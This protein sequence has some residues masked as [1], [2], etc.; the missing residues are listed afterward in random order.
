MYYNIDMNYC[1]L[2]IYSGYTFLSSTLKVDDIFKICDKSSIKYFGI[3]DLLNMHAY[4]DITNLQNKYKSQPIYGSTI[5]YLV[6]D[7]YPFLISLY[8]I[9]EEGYLNLVKI[10]S[11]YPEGITLN[12]LKNFTKGLIAIIPTISN[13]EIY[14]LLKDQDFLTL[15]KELNEL[16]NIFENIYLGV[17]IYQ[18]KDQYL[19]NLLR[20]FSKNKHFELVAFNK[21][22]YLT[23]QDAIGLSILSAIKNDTKLT[24]KEEEG[25]YFF[26]KEKVLLS[27]YTNQEINNTLLIADKCSKFEFLIKRGSLLKFNINNK[28]EFI[29]N[30]CLK[31]LNDKNLNNEKYLNRLNYELDIIDKMGYLDYFLI[32]EDYVNYCKNNN[33]PVGPGRGSSAGSLV[34]YLLNITEID[35]CKYDLLFE[36]FLNPERI[37][38]PDIDIDFA[39]YLRDDVVKYIFNKYGKNKCANIVTFQTLGAKSSLRDIGR[40]FSIN[41]NDI[42]LLSKLIG[43]NDSL[44]N[45]YK[46]NE[47]FKEL[48]QDEYFLNIVILAKKIEGLPRQTGLHAAGIIINNDYLFNS[49]PVTINNEGT[50]ISQFEAPLLE[51]LGYLKMDILGL[52]NLTIIESMEKYINHYY[53]PNFN[54]KNIPLNDE[55][56]FLILNKGLTSGIFQ[57]ESSGITSSLKKVIIN[58]F[59]SLVAIL[60]LYRPGPMDNIPTYSRNKNELK[61]IEYLDPILEPIL[62]STYGVI[63]YQE[64]IMQIVQVVASFS[65]GKAD[66][67]RRAISKKDSNK[68][69]ELKEDFING[70]LKNGFS[71]D[72]ANQI[73]NLIFK[74]ANYGFNKSHSVSYAFIS[75]QM[76]YIKA[77]YPECFFASIL[78]QLPLQDSRISTI[79]QEL[80]YFNINL[81]LP[82]INISS[83][84]YVIK[85]NNLYIPFSSIKGIN[86]TIINSL[87]KI[88]N[89]KD[90]STFMKFANEEKIPDDA[91]I[92]LI[93]AGCF[94][95]FNKTRATLRNSITIYKNY[96][97]SITNEGQLTQEELLLLQPII[98]DI[99]EN[100]QLKYELEYNTLGLLLSGSLFNKYKKQ[101]KNN[102]IISIKDLYN[103]NI[104]YS[105]TIIAIIKKIRII[106][107]KKNQTMASLLLQDDSMIITAI[108][109]PKTYNETSYLLK[110]NEVIMIKGY[111]KYEENE[112]TFICNN[113]EK[114]EED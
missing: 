8:I 18:E 73:Y 43:R 47:E 100:E 64:Q 14:F 27:L 102:N 71:L 80:N 96:Y 37:S 104:T 32:V 91:I 51:K 67:F 21:H 86:K 38:M 59:N 5:K 39:D 58:D 92:S 98:N 70:A 3:C 87:C 101:I 28:K 24:K 36:R 20:D 1:P 114:L 60:A 82:S 75:Y 93:N 41:N 66:L 17:E 48:L 45:A 22:L 35:S 88:N 50:L 99:E 111:F 9:N 26:L 65:L 30:K 78:N 13:E 16:K 42:S 6:N 56:T 90:F 97:T 89:I 81:K 76:A 15:E 11:L 77:N 40:V 106:K 79:I 105:S 69:I 49:I 23:K 19:I 94:D 113:I 61:K 25:P 84:K 46:Y 110:Q 68:L 44:T 83:N 34:S 7:E 109:F 31:S 33:I 63:I 4:S 72:K 107:T 57:L 103:K 12:E 10:I 53:D 85:D 29:Y 108:V 74:F 95:E 2:N 55:K 62:S 52:T 54:I 112:T